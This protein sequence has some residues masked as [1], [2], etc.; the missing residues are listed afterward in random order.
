MLMWMKR[1]KI[2]L[3]EINGCFVLGDLREFA[4]Q[5][6]DHIFI[7][8]DNDYIVISQNNIANKIPGA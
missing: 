5:Y 4:E 3:T 2:A 6:G 8:Y 1:E 7:Q